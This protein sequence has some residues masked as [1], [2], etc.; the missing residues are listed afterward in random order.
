MSDMRR[1]FFSCFKCHRNSCWQKNGLV[2]TSF[3]SQ[4]SIPKSS[5]GKVWKNVMSLNQEK[6]KRT[7]LPSS[8]LYWS[9]STS[10]HSRHLVSICLREGFCR[11]VED[12]NSASFIGNNDVV[13]SYHDMRNL[14]LEIAHWNLTMCSLQTVFLNVYL[15]VEC[16]S[17]SDPSKNISAQGRCGC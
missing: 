12:G 6:A 1:D 5:I 15:K 13:P 9:I 3:P 11:M 14:F 2:W 10:G 4:R 7:A 17:W 8:T 16:S